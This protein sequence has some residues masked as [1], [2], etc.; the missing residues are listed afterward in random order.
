LEGDENNE[1]LEDDARIPLGSSTNRNLKRPCPI[2]AQ[3]PIAKINTLPS[4]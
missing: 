4:T 3:S 1:A 2:G